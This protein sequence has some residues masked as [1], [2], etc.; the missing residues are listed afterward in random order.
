MSGTERRVSEAT[1]PGFFLTRQGGDTANFSRLYSSEAPLPE[2]NHVG[3]N[4]SRYMNR[5]LDALLD[6]YYVTIPI[7]ERREV[8][9]QII[10]H[11]SD[12]LV[13]LPLFYGAEPIVVG[14]RVRNVG[15]RTSS[16]TSGWNAHEWD[17][18]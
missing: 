17:V 7:A 10:H 1:R 3:N 5:E 14:N 13:M 8:I 9:G 11:I 12:Q 2:N 6:R 16:A 18:S 15:P 4:A